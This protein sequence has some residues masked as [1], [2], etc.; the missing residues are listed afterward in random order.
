M[1]LR[2]NITDKT[3]FAGGTDV[4]PYFPDSD[5]D[6]LFFAEGIKKLCEDHCQDYVQLQK[7]RADFFVSKYRHEKVGSHAG[8]YSFQLSD[9]TFSFFKG[10]SEA[11]FVA[12][13][14][15]VSPS[16]SAARLIMTPRTRK[17]EKS[18]FVLLPEALMM[19]VSCHLE[20]IPIVMSMEK[21]DANGR[22]YNIT[23]GV[24]RRRYWMI[25][26]TGGFS[27]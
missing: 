18:L 26:R 9:H 15:T 24:C 23:L 12:A 3:V 1:E 13:G 7:T 14:T 25:I 11:F 16:T 6:S 8:I 10:I 2:A 17:K 5:Q 21:S 27:L 19:T 22:A 20:A 4:F